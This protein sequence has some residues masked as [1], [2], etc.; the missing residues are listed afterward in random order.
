MILLTAIL[1]MHFFHSLDTDDINFREKGSS[2]KNA[3]FENAVA[4]KYVRRS[5]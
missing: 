4:Q 3:T 5:R 1:S 2:K